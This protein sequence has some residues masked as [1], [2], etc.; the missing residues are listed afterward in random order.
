MGSIYDAT[1]SYPLAMLPIVAFA[2]V[3][4]VVLALL[5]RPLR[6]M[7]AAQAE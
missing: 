6:A 2:G 4:T 5:G 7:A 1:H 3:A